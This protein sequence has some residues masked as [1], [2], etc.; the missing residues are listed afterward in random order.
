MK[1]QTEIELVK[2]LLTLKAGGSA[3]LDDSV[4]RNPVESYVS[5]EQFM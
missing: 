5:D 4:E 2:E 1:R 3:F